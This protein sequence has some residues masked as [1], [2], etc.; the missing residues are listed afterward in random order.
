[1]VAE[2]SEQV[3]GLGEQFSHLNLREFSYTP[4]K[5][6]ELFSVSR[7]RDRIYPI[8]TREQGKIYKKNVTPSMR[9][10]HGHGYI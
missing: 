6:P 7:S 10:I 8:W 4:G 5:D 9:N 1:M 3:Y 2:A